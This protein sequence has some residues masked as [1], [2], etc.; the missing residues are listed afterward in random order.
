MM[1]NSCSLGSRVRDPRFKVVSGNDGCIRGA[2]G[3]VETAAKAGWKRNAFQACSGRLY[4]VSV[5]KVSMVPPMLTGDLK[6]KFSQQMTYVAG[7]C[8]AMPPP[9]FVM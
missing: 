3:A 2:S 7:N 6:K 9:R 8:F 1:A 5:I 4:I